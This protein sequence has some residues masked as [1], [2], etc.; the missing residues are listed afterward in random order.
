MRVVGLKLLKDFQE[1]HADSKNALE[2]WFYEAK[3]ADWKSF[4][5]VKSRYAS[6]SNIG[7][8]R[9]V[10]N[11]RGNKYRLVVKFNYRAGLAAIRFVG[12]HAEYDRINAEEV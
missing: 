4:M 12:T 2:S 3:N 8:S 11:I 5:D 1:K 7:N 10:F 6:A 9:V